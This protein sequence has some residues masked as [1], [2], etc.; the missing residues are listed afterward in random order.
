MAGAGSLQRSPGGPTPKTDVQLAKDAWK[1]V[2]GH[3]QK[4]RDQKTTETDLHKTRSQE[5]DMSKANTIVASPDD[6][7]ARK[8]EK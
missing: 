7:S 1:Y 2:R 6:Q 8:A 3:I 5:S 4:H